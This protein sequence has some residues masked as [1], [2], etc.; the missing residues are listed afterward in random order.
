MGI[1]STAIRRAHLSPRA[2]LRV[3][4]PPRNLSEPYITARFILRPGDASQGRSK[5]AEGPR[6]RYGRFERC[7]EPSARAAAL[8]PL[9]PVNGTE[10]VP[11]PPLRLPTTSLKPGQ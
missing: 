7:A 2:S 4:A 11:E 10:A 5:S 3:A 1:F 6:S 9:R 8:V